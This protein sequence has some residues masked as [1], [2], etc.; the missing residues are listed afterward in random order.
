M[1]SIVA[2]VVVGYL[3]A[4][5]TWLAARPLLALPALARHNFRG[6]SL[7]TAAGIVLPLAAVLVEGG[8]A[9]VASFGVG[10][11]PA[12]G[13]RLLVLAAAL[14]FGL[15]GLI[16]DLAGGGGGA[17]A[18]GGGTERGFRGHLGAL[19]QG[20]VTTGVLKLFGGA[21]L[22]L[23]LVAPFVGESPGRLLADAALVALCANLANL[24]DRAPGRTIKAGLGAFV[25]LLVA[26]RSAEDLSGIAVIIGASLGLFLDDLHER[27]MLGDAGSNVLGAVLGLGIVAAC[28]EA[29]RDV[30]LVAVAGL[31][32]AG[33]LVS[34]SKVID[35]VPPL[36]AVDQ[37]GRRP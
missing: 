19:V 1:R 34:F 17:P 5:L 12:R 10:D 25:L 33:E 37:A 3:A 32:V 26:V 16:D 31:N 8:R 9:V 36:R 35:A 2:A 15:L 7:P 4:R 22:A 24:F 23:V 28:G 30:A 14:G 21:V 13:A 29:A 11:G 27:L 18:A 6:R 20:R